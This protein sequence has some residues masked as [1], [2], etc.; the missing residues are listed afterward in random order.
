VKRWREAGLLRRVETL[1]GVVLLVVVAV[2]GIAISAATDARHATD[3]RGNRLGPAN[4]ATVEL[5]AAYTDEETGVRGYLV[6]QDP[7]YLSPYRKAQAQLPD[8]Y[9]RLQSLLADEPAL[10][11]QLRRVVTD[12]D[13]WVRNV[14][15]P[16]I[17][18][19]DRGDFKAA[20]DIERSGQGR[21]RFDIVQ[22]SSGTL[23]AGI[24][25]SRD[26]ESR[27]ILRAQ[28]VLLATLVAAVVLV[29]A[30]IVAA[31]LAVSRGLIRPFDRVRLAVD[32]VAGGDLRTAVPSTGPREVAELGSSVEAMRARL[33]ASLEE[34]RRAV[35]AL[36]QQGPAVIALRDALAPAVTQSSQ[37]VIAGRLDP[38]E[39]VLAGDWYD[40]LDL[41]NGRV[42]L[43][44]G[45]VS[46]HGPGP[47]VF[48]LRLKHL[49]A[50]ALTTGMSPAMSV[51]WVVG[52]L[53]DTGEIFASAVVAVLDPNTGLLEYV[54][55]GHP[56][57]VVIRAHSRQLLELPSSGPI[58]TRIVF[59]H[60]AWAAREL[61]LQPGDL[62]LA[63]TDGLVEARR[64]D[65]QELGTSGLFEHLGGLI[66]STLP[67]SPDALLDEVFTLVER[68]STAPAADDRTALAVARTPVNS[69][70]APQATQQRTGVAESHAGTSSSGGGT[71]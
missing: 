28:N 25:A 11:E 48:A 4:T 1:A 9:G 60:G 34:S 15:Q 33:V 21:V 49:L 53:G 35:E 29:L 71:G 30:L 44:I 13:A 37:L 12:H 19:A 45:D 43:I 63:Y 14:A 8:R 65:G 52:Q 5:L 10:V 18:A 42:G 31:V 50:A 56:E 62:F 36:T 16:E 51:E 59:S 47:G 6:T 68:Y 22:Q 3:R 38:A 23:Q 46:G 41:P 32:A 54:N 20:A 7:S 24:A 2:L 55:A 67:P 69:E 27:R 61:T 17:A 39:G 64:G 26:A 57:A 66:G 40:A 58:L 70:P